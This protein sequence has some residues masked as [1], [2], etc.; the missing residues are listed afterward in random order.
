MVKK[1]SVLL[2]LVIMLAVNAMAVLLPLNNKSTKELSDAIPTFFVPE[3]YVFSIWSII[4]L[5][6]LAY[7]IYQLLPQAKN[8][9]RLH[10][11]AWLFVL[12][13]FSNA[14]WIFLWH[15]EYV[16]TS[17]VFMLVILGTLIGIYRL[18]GIGIEK[19]NNIE[20]WLTHFPFSLYLGWISVA[21]IANIAAALYVHNWSAWGIA[22]QLWS[23]LMLVVATVLSITMLLKYRDYVFA[24][25]IVWAVIG[26]GRNFSEDSR[27]LWTCVASVIVIVVVAVITFSQK[28]RHKRL[29]SAQ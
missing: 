19:V 20:Y 23:V 13:A 6:L 18:L 16:A 1:I 25:V 10:G 27:I 8:N 17:V 4:Y 2:G 26:I 5:A 14:G 3:G 7:A 21:T 22:P 11:I 12:N 9:T 28:G 24:G 15:Y 29:G